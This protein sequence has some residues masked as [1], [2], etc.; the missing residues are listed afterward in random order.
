[1]GCPP[2]PTGSK[3]K[4]QAHINVEAC[5]QSYLINYLFKYYNKGVTA[6]RMA[7]SAAPPAANTDRGDAE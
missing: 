2:Q 4:I 1:M 3:K 7:I 5:N 6:A